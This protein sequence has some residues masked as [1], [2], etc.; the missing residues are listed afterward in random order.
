MTSSSNPRPCRKRTWRARS[1]A[2]AGW[3]LNL[4]CQTA[5]ARSSSPSFKPRQRGGNGLLGNAPVAQVAL[6]PARAEAGLAARASAARSR[7]TRTASRA[8]RAPPARAS[9]SP[10][11]AASRGEL[12]RQLAAA[13]ARG[14]RAASAPARAGSQPH[15][16]V[17]ARER[18]P[19]SSFTLAQPLRRLPASAWL[20]L[21]APPAGSAA[22]RRAAAHAQRRAYL[23][24]DLARDLGILLQVVA[25]VVLALADAVLAV[26]VPGARSCRRCGAATP[27]SMISPSREM[28]SP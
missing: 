17:T 15:R 26:G 2:S 5:R 28:P 1:A 7:A 11:S 12:A 23:A 16:A 21:G 6:Y 22:A 10:G 9:I 25:R 14:A 4:R 20:V 18:A 19:P 13:C 27:S 8:P 24:L 3:R